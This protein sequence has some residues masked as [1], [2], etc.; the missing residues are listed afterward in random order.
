MGAVLEVKDMGIRFGGLVALDGVNIDVPE[1][2]IVGLIGPNGAGKTTLFNCV[3]GLYQ[4]NNGTVQYRGRDISLLPTHRKVALGIGRTWQNIGLVR[5]LSVLENLLLAQHPRIRYGALA[6][7][8]GSP[9]TFLEERRLRANAMEVLDFL[10]LAHL[11]DSKL[12]GLPYGTLKLIE[13]G[14]VLA[15]DPDVVL[16]DEPS[17]G[18]GPDEAHAFGERLIRLR[19]ELN[20]TV[21]MIEHHV[22]LVTEVCDYVY[23]LNFG[24]VLTHGKPKEVQRHPEVIA[25]YLGGDVE[26][27]TSEEPADATS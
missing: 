25:A 8:F 11:A 4:P 17:S 2:E 16:L 26:A 14:T 7:I 13:I 22:P 3:M 21:L 27:D 10:G 6:A 9:S 12:D 5:E 23:V 1:W 18:M 24:K 20:L 15:T 19:Q